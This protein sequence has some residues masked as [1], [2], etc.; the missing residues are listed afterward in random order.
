MQR[1]VLAGILL[2]TALISLIAIIYSW[3]YQIPVNG[4]VIFIMLFMIV[5]GVAGTGIWL[6]KKWGIIL[7][8][9]FY[10]PQIMN[11]QGTYEFMSP[12]TLGVTMGIN[13]IM[14]YINILAIAMT[15]LL[16]KQLKET[17]DNV[18]SKSS[19]D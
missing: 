4:V 15:V 10:V 16:V 2:L 12:I 19:L 14:I 3:I 9:L 7:G 13:Q 8:L 17:K 5:P 11:I 18:I 6:K 1:K